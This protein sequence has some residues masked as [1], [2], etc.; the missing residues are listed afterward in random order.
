MTNEATRRQLRAATPGRSTWLTANAGSGKTRVLTDRVARLLLTG[1]EPQRI[2]CLTYTKAAASEMQNR[3]FAKLGT[4]AMQREDALRAALREIGVEETLTVAE[5]ARARTLFARAIETPGGLKI[6]TIH[7]FCAAILRRFPLEAGVSPDF[8]EMDQRVSHLM[9][10]EVLD[11]LAR[12]GAPGFPA[13]A[14]EQTHDDLGAWLDEILRHKSALIQPKTKEA[15]WAAF[16][17]PP[18]YDWAAHARSVLAPGDDALLTQVAAGLQRSGANDQKLA[19]RIAALDLSPATPAVFAELEDMFVYG[20]DRTQPFTSK[21]PRVPTKAG[22]DL[23]GPALTDAFHALMERVAEARPRRTG[24]VAAARDWALHAFAADFLPAYEAKKAQGGWLDFDDLIARTRALLAESD[25]AAWVLF[26][27]D[28]GIDHILVDEA[29]DTSPEQWEIIKA[30]AAEILAGQG[31]REDAARTVFVVGDKKQSIYSFQGADPR[32]FDSSHA[33]FE[34]MLGA[35]EEPLQSLALEHSFRS[36][37]AILEVVDRVFAEGAE[38]GL[39]QASHHIAFKDALPG[40]VDLL[41][42][43]AD[44]KSDP[45]PWWE[46]VDA[47]GQEDPARRLGEDM[48]ARIA[49][50]LERSTLPVWKDGARQDRAV[51]PRDILILVQSRSALFSEIIRACKNA[52]I[53]LAGADQLHVAQELAVR[54]ITALLSFLATPE[55][56]LSLASALKSPLFGWDERALF[57][58]AHHRV[59]SYLWPAL[60]DRASDF[61]DTVAALQGLLAQAD[62]LRPF[63][64]IERILTRG[65]GRRA[66]VARL[67]PEAE[68]AIDALLAQSIAYEQT[69]PPSLTGFLTWLA[70]DTLKVKR[71]ID[72]TANVVRVMTVHGAKGLEAPIVILPDTAERRASRPPALVETEAGPAWAPRAE[73][74]PVPLIE[75]RQAAR[76]R[77]LEERQRLL[78][79]AMTRAES[80]LIVGAAG[81]AESAETSW[82]AQIAGALEGCPLREIAGGWRYEPMPWPADRQPTDAGDA[83][84]LTPLDVPPP[85]AAP[86]S[87]AVRPSDLGGAK[88]LEGTEEAPE[89]L[90]RGSA[91]HR[92]LERLPPLPRG[93]WAEAAAREGLTD[94]LSEAEAL[95]GD[96]ALAALF[97]PGTL[98]EVDVTARLPAFAGRPLRGS[99]D[100]LLIEDDRVL[101]VDFKSNRIVPETAE[102]VPEGILRQLGAYAEALGAI[103]PGKSVETAILWTQ[104]RHLMPV[105]RDAA[106]AALARASMA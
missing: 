70:A 96:P 43:L 4:W 97:A 75:A 93:D 87:R 3:L 106:R 55:D 25:V 90:D 102:D 91:L 33:H 101:A 52:G 64:L 62:F 63:E 30:L 76:Q 28:G 67:G 29:Q 82:H 60:R 23:L 42:P 35:A 73:D 40:R 53:P 32:A 2:L 104:T 92:L 44:V 79:V 78:Y 57:E 65:G 7:A 95:L 47:L 34:E 88:T 37:P 16:G 36:A 105:S 8:R 66:L 22:K 5:L 50:I 18:G 6:Q 27:L 10:R 11:A 19:A 45:A 48:A 1:V 100:R 81:K 94:C 20:A 83:A 9:Q 71:A 103:F 51:E 59:Q 12:D 21:S 80:W 15:V 46:A 84:A 26:R 24:L 13:M 68:D 69:E 17:L 77:A 49:A 74:M 54:D 56:D 98:A 58:L 39:G 38:R 72:G 86:G 31:A 85:P 14:A 61:P 41:E 99:I 89:A